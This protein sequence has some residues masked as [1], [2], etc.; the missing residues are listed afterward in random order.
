M[1]SEQPLPPDREPPPTRPPRRHAERDWDD[2]DLE[3][4]LR[5]RDEDDG[6]MS[7][8]IPTR[9]PKA[10]IAYYCGVFSIIC[11]VGLVLGP[12][13]LIL[14]ILGLR[15]V[16][17]N[18]SAK[19]TGH[20]IAGIVLG[21]LTTL[22][23]WGAIIVLLVSLAWAA[24]T[25]PKTTPG[26]PAPRLGI[27]KPLDIEQPKPL[28]AE[29]R[30]LI[31]PV[32]KWEFAPEPGE[33]AV[34]QV[35]NSEVQHVAFSPDG[36]Y[37]A[38]ATGES[39]VEVW[40]VANEQR[41]TLKQFATGL[42]FSRDGTLLALSNQGPTPSVAVYDPATVQLVQT[43][44]TAKPQE[45]AQAV[46]FSPDGSTLAAITGETVRLWE[47]GSW[48]EKPGYKTPGFW[49]SDLA[50]SPDGKVLA[51]AA[52]MN[53]VR[54]WNVG[55]G[56]EKSNLKG[57]DNFVTAVAFCSDGK[58]VA[59]TSTDTTVKLWDVDQGKV[60]LSSKAHTGGATCVAFSPDGKLLAS[61]GRDGMVRLW[62]VSTN[63]AKG[64]RK[65]HPHGNAINSLAFS[66]DGL[67]LVSASHG[68]IKA[69]EVDKMIGP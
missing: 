16:K 47:A 46:T 21:A 52:P 53:L 29:N 9:N 4:R 7:T 34:I 41:R 43:V 20:A 58:H 35:A 1:Q 26:G 67:T 62:D 44:Y 51:A 31:N 56:K 54:L 49:S 60:Q 45:G 24:Y 39:K 2:E 69:W 59:T 27:D 13:A 40:E 15:Y 63:A 17:A 8:L 38:A 22:V 19:G 61:G 33:R 50:F 14:G 11:G 48:R 5:R 68:I 30:D 28:F 18:P 36:K 10:L 32:R 65:G 42:S 6:G 3:R 37:F 66:P 57:H 12:I 25:S 23:Y 64:T 55:E